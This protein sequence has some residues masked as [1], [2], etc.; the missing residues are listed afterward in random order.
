[1]GSGTNI[2]Y[3][4]GLTGGIGSGKTVV[5]DHFATLGVPVIDTDVIARI[6]VEP[7]QPA[8]AE[9]V[10]AF[11]EQVL[12]ADGKLDRSA[13]RNIAFASDSNKATLDGITHPA[14]RTETLAQIQQVAYSYCIVVV[15]L[16]VPDSAFTSFMRRILVVVADH[17]TKVERVMK[18]SNLS[19]AEVERIMRTQLSDEERAGFADDVIHNDG[20]IADA[21]RE[22]ESLHQQYLTDSQ[23]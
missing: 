8:L 5:S 20:T 17:Q 11:G 21:H 3:I 15:P 6:V 12:Q 4:V 1:M 7:G 9:L 18:R 14:I 13:L 19:A 16:L 23:A 10:A 22:V 2:P